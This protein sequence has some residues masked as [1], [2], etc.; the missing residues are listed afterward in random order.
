MNQVSDAKLALA[1]QRA[2][3]FPSL[4]IPNDINGDR[5]D[6]AK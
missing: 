3:A 4:S 2:S 1:V 5:F 6:L